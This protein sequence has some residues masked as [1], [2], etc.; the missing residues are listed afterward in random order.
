MLLEG[1]NVSKKYSNAGNA[2][3]ALNNVSLSLSAG[4]FAAVRGYSGS[5]KS[6]LFNLI[7]GLLKPDI[8]QI[9]FEGRC[10]SENNFNLSDYRNN[11]IGYI[12]RA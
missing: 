8:G 2:F 5:G 12:S 10:I 4:K 6:T 3:Y 7:S 11:R 1:Q 9:L